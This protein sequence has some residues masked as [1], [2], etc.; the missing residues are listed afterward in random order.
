MKVA[1]FGS[2]LL[3][4]SLA[5]AILGASGHV[6]KCVRVARGPIGMKTNWNIIDGRKCGAGPRARVFWLAAR[7]SCSIFARR[8]VGLDTHCQEFLMEAGRNCS[9]YMYIRRDYN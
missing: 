5:S 1:I 9:I 3:A 2:A 8:G 7:G 4:G 6:R